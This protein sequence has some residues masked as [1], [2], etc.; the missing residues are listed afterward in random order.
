MEGSTYPT[1]V[2][3]FA[4]MNLG[5]TPLDANLVN[6]VMAALTATQMVVGANPADQSAI[7]GVNGNFADVAAALSARMQLE[8]G[9]FTHA[10]AN[11]SESVSFAAARF[12]DTPVVF[13]M[14]EYGSLGTDWLYKFYATDKTTSGFT[15][16]RYVNPAYTKKDLDVRYL[17]IA[18]P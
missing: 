9:S 15:C 3:A 6:E 14:P 18:L 10:A 16:R 12:T 8:V 7:Y 5:T 13:L 11:A 4:T 2:D 17:A 1:A